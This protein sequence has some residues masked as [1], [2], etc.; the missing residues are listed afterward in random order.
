MIRNTFRAAAKDAAISRAFPASPA[1]TNMARYCRSKD[2]MIEER[3]TH[4]YI[5]ALLK[6]KHLKT[7]LSSELCP[8]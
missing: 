4:E 1:A 5:M 8:I 7:N 3:S 2:V 6:E